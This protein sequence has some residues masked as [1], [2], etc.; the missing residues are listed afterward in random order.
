MTK[1]G[2]GRAI[3]LSIT[4]VLKWNTSCCSWLKVYA[5]IEYVSD[6]VDITKEL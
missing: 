4:G 2:I 6:N 5:V 1:Y 3:F